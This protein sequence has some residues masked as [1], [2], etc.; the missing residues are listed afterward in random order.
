M[1]VFVLLNTKEYILK[2]V[3]NQAVLGT[4]DFHSRKTNTMEVNGVPE[5]LCFLHSSEYLSLCSAE[6]RHSYRCGTT[7]GGA[8]DDRIFIF[9]STIPLTT[10]L[11][12]INKQQKRLLLFSQ[13]CVIQWYKLTI[14]SWS[15]V[16]RRE[17]KT[18]MFSEL[19]VYISKMSRF[20]NS[21]SWVYF[22][23]FWLFFSF[24]NTLF[25]HFSNVFRQ[26]KL[27]QLHN[28]VFSFPTQFHNLKLKESGRIIIK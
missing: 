2:K 1:N 8:N 20:F 5:Q 21:R 15:P 3:C 16:L 24:F 27:Q 13:N 18:D 10:T 9:V 4:I 19:R 25:I 14:A 17:K 28:Y 11:L 26:K 6:Q 7:W 22:S 12:S 23:Q